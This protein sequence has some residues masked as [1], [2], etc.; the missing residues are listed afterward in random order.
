MSRDTE[1]VV[2]RILETHRFG[3]HDVIVLEH[4]DDDGTT[5]SVLVDNMP[6]TDPLPVPPSF[7]DIVLIYARTLGDVSRA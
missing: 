2:E 4:A 6:V 1:A 7:A 3:P 5:Y